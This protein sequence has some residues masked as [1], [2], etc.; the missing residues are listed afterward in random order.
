MSAAPVRY[1]EGSLTSWAAAGSAESSQVETG[2]LGP[3]VRAR[4]SYHIGVAVGSGPA[5]VLT[6]HDRESECS[7]ETELPYLSALPLASSQAAR[8][9]E[10]YS[11]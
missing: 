2:R 6:V 5:E 7:N 11:I 9:K 4:I 10:A 1:I 3:G 8:R